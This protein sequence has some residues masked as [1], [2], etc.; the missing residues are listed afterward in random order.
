MTHSTARRLVAS[1]L[2]SGWASAPA[3]AHTAW[4]EPD[5]TVSGWQLKFGGHAGVL[6]PVVPGK[7][8]DVA[9]LDAEGKALTV[10]RAVNGDQVSIDVAGEPSV[11]ALH[12]DNGIHTRPATP[13]PSIEQPM[14]AVPGAISA[15]NAVKY[16]KTIAAWTP[17]VVRPVGQEFEVI[18]LL[19]ATPKAGVP[20]TVEV[21]LKGQPLA[22]A[23]IGHGEDS[24]DAVTDA[25]GRAQFTPKAGFNKLWA[26]Q[27]FEVEG[28]PDYTQLSYEYLLGFDA[29]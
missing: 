4:L 3:L 14:H 8:K 2:L 12:Y 19:A 13:G 26:G 6:E 21:R 17:Q 1:L 29:E 20:M 5:T 27:R 10:T 28:N 16:H 18:P 11:I 15:V 23:K 22:G 7:L 24:G 9:A 25:Q